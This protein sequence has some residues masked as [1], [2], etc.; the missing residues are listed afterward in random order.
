MSAKPLTAVLFVMAGGMAAQQTNTVPGDVFER[1]VVRGLTGSGGDEI[2][3]LA[4]DGRGNSYIA[5]STTS[6]DFPI[7]NAAQTVM[8]ESHLVVSTD[9]GRTWTGLGLI[10]GVSAPQFFVD[11]VPG[12]TGEGPGSLVVH[13]AKAGVLFVRTEAGLMKT[14]DNGRNWRKVFA[15]APL[16]VAV[17]AGSPAVMYAVQGGT[18]LVSED[19]GETWRQRALALEPGETISEVVADGAGAVL[20]TSRGSRSG[21]ISRDRGANWVRVRFPGTAGVVR[22]DP[23]HQG[24]IYVSV[25]LGSEGSL[26]ASE[27]WGATW[28]AKT[29][30]AFWAV[31]QMLFD[32]ELAGVIYAADGLD[33]WRSEDGGSQW[34]KLLP[35][36]SAIRGVTAVV[37][38]ACGGGGLV[39]TG[40]FTSEIYFSGDFGGEWQAGMVTRI[41]Q[42]RV[43]PG[44][45]IYATRGVSADAFVM[46]VDGNGEVVWSTYLGGLAHEQV[47]DVSVDEAGNV[48]VTGTTFVSR[49]AGSADFMGFIA[50]FDAVGRL[51]YSRPLFEGVG[52]SAGIDR[53]GNAYTAGSRMVTKVGPDGTEVWARAQGWDSQ[54][55]AVD[56]RG[57]SVV[58][59][60]GAIR[61]LD[62]EG[63]LVEVDT[64]SPYSGA[65]LVKMDAQGN[66]Y[67]AG[68]TMAADFPVIGLWR[69]PSRYC[70][71]LSN[72]VFF[73]QRGDA[74]V[75]KLGPDG[76]VRYSV[77]L[78]GECWGQP[79]A[80]AV[81]TD[82]RAFVVVQTQSVAF[83]LR[84]PAAIG[85][86]PVGL[87]LAQIEKDG[88]EL[89]FATRLPGS[90]WR[91]YRQ[92]I[93][94]TPERGLLFGLHD[95]PHTLLARLGYAPPGAV[96][97]DMVGNAF[98]GASLAI[99]PGSLVSLTGTNLG[100][101]TAEDLGLQAAGPLPLEL[102]GTQ[103]LFDGVAAKL[104]RVSSGQV[105]C[106][107]PD[108]L[109][110]RTRVQ[111]RA[112]GD[113]SNAVQVAV[114]G[115][116]IELLTR[117]YPGVDVFAEWPAGEI[118]NETGESNDRGHPAVA[119]RTITALVTGV[120]LAPTASVPA[121]VYVQ[122]SSIYQRLEGSLER[123]EGFVEGVYLLRMK[124]PAKPGDGVYELGLSVGGTTPPRVEIAPGGASRTVSVFVQ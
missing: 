40:G 14:V 89:S 113:V 16:S 101:A 105:I 75:V 106:V 98:R 53:S 78:S 104:V 77:R 67:L 69:P 66:I 93:A 76:T 24:T 80:L 56:E 61:R 117:D 50:K 7:R 102:A 27:N 108:G 9:R 35:V 6:P 4:A 72:D 42:V 84:Q 12:Y 74:Y 86:R 94:A 111:V 5:G 38:R 22:F 23:F 96:S 19:E 54:S 41:S 37:P 30:P 116:R 120:G 3:A 73:P 70:A 88:S 87:I 10:P 114:S 109:Q 64:S 21:L 45:S 121:W 118:W 110:E 48:L 91:M 103:V 68:V 82:G 36:T 2:G 15:P 65:R 107:A 81:G 97:L 119:G 25:S 32:P 57:N 52:A 123:A 18:L 58:V 17:D 90:Q 59:G 100:P 43:G 1:L 62:A 39:G 28:M 124:I 51:V 122:G 49:G 46:K 60:G 55:I 92:V 31:E 33:T 95:Y 29:N 26:Y 34:T 13:P 8:G 11:T 85:G 47:S 112:R 79:V 44:C 71:P 20:V 83:P 115:T 99:A 63:Q